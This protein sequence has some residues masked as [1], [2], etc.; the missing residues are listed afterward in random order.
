M[1]VIMYMFILPW[2]LISRPVNLENITFKSIPRHIF[3]DANIDLNR[4]HNVQVSAS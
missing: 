3:K 1:Y 4:I 2:S